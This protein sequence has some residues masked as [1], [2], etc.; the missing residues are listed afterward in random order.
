MVSSQD[1]VFSNVKRDDGPMKASGN[2][3]RWIC[4]ECV[5]GRTEHL[6]KVSGGTALKRDKAH[7]SMLMALFILANFNMISQTVKAKKRFRTVVY[8]PEI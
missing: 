3:E 7:W 4:S 8:I 6:I 2:M 1:K 5:G